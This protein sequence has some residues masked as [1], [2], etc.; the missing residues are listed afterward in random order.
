MEQSLP[1]KRHEL[2][3]TTADMKCQTISLVTKF[4]EFFE[5]RP[6]GSNFPKT[7]FG[8]TPLRDSLIIDR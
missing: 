8:R 6:T 7:S 2:T 1:N 4:M 5:N 3:I